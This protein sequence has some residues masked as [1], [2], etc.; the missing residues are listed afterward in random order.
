MLGSAF[1][2]ENVCVTQGSGFTNLIT[3]VCLLGV[4]VNGH[5]MTQALYM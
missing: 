2:A 1:V 5:D 4:G 3:L